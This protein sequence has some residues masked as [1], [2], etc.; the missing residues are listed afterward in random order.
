[1]KKLINATDQVL[2]ESLSGF[3]SAHA[4]LLELGAE[5]KFIC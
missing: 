3:V 2:T 5:G 4:D 1:M